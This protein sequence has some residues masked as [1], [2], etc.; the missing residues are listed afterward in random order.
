MPRKAAAHIAVMPAYPTPPVI[1]PPASLSEPAKAIFAEIVGCCDVDHFQQADV[2]LLA[3]Y[4]T[5]A[6]LVER[7]EPH[8]QGDDDKPPD[9]KWVS[10]WR[11]ANKSMS[12][13]ALRLRL[14]PQSRRE[15]AASK[16]KTLTWSERVGLERQALERPR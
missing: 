6:A 5:A 4:A 16:P 14:G 3:A 1:Q 13:L 10:T 2:H 7:C 15:R 11:E 8:L 9:S 12:N